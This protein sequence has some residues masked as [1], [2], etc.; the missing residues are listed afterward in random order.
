MMSTRRDCG[1]VEAE[2]M[3]GELVPA[4]RVLSSMFDKGDVR[5]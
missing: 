4:F 2:D 5:E 1:Q 3:F